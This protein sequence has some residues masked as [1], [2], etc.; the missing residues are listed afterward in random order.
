MTKYDAEALFALM[1][2]PHWTAYLSYKAGR[3]DKLH[4][5]MEWEDANIK[6]LQGQIAEI[7]D[8][9]SLQNTVTDFLNHL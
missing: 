6:R 8:D 4:K 5:D 7:R 3:L 9:L 2:S 1:A